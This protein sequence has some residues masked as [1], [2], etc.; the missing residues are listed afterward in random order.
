ML[1][2]TSILTT[3]A[4]GMITP[5]SNW[6]PPPTPA[7]SLILSGMSREICGATSMRLIPSAVMSSAGDVPP[8][9]VYTTVNMLPSLCGY[10]VGDRLAK[11]DDR[12]R[13][14]VLGEDSAHFLERD[15]HAV[16]RVT[17]IISVVEGT[18]YTVVH[19]GC[20]E[21]Y[22][23]GQVHLCDELVR[24]HDVFD[25]LRRVRAPYFLDVIVDFCGGVVPCIIRQVIFRSDD[26]YV[27]R[28]IQIFYDFSYYLVTDLIVSGF[29]TT[30]PDNRALYKVVT[31]NTNLVTFFVAHL[32]TGYR[33]HPHTDFCVRHSCL[34]KE[35][36]AHNSIDDVLTAILN[37]EAAGL[38]CCK[39]KAVGLVTKRKI[40]AEACS[41]RSRVGIPRQQVAKSLHNTDNCTCR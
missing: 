41:R 15:R 1:A 6:P 3:L 17:D 36:T 12:V 9:G 7:S 26:D 16:L 27:C 29:G 32:N 35:C 40:E 23:I 4:A 21:D 34:G 13:V 19:G 11:L 14:R 28:Q 38:L 5:P 2:V 33:V 22:A 30:L 20:T 31:N 10:K 24:N 18:K 25:T 8:T 37:H 39:Q